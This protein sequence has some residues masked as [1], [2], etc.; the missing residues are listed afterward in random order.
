[1]QGRRHISL[2]LT[3]LTVAVS[4]WS[5]ANIGRPSGGEK[6]S[7][8][9]EVLGVLPYPGTLYFNYK[10]IEFHFDEF[11][12]PGNYKDEVFISPMPSVDP[13]VVVKNKV[14]RIKFLGPLR[15]N[16]TYV[17][18]LGTGIVDYNEGNKMGQSYTYA[19]STG[20]VLDSLR[21]TGHVSDMWTGG[22]EVNMRIMLFRADAIEVDEIK[23]KRPEYLVTTDKEGKF[24]FKYLA[25]GEY[26]IYGVGDADNNARY[27]GISE[28]I[29]LAANPL[30]VLK[31]GDS[32]APKVEMVA[33]FQDQDAP[34]AKSAKWSNAYTIHVEF[35]EP[36]RTSFGDDSLQIELSDT[37]GGN[38]K[39]LLIKRFRD[40]D[41]RHLYL[42]ADVPRTQD[43]DLH[44]KG[45]LDSLGQ[46]SEV[47][48]R[49]AA[50]SQVRE[51]RNKWFETPINERRGHEFVVHT[52]FKL[53]AQLD[54]SQVQLLD[55]AGAPQ[56]VIWS[57]DG[58]SL[59]AKSPTML[60]PEL[61]YT[62]RLKKNIL[63]PDGKSL[64]TLVSFKMTFPN[65]DDYGTITG[66][67]LADSTRPD[68]RFQMI[69]RGGQGTGLL[70]KARAMDKESKGKS[71]GAAAVVDRFEERFAA[72]APF[73]FVYLHPGNYSIDIIDDLDGNGVL[74]P[75]SLV[76]YR[77]PEKVYHQATPVDIKAKWDLK[78][79]EIYP[80]PQ[81]GKA[82]AGKGGKAGTG[83]AN[84]PTPSPK[85]K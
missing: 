69:L 49:V 76:P 5:C 27:T 12:K 55:T 38:R 4:V 24:D 78:D 21:F 35:S 34:T 14:L 6:D 42:H 20:A 72:P 33:F 10:E 18:T 9:P 85:G 79:V 7:A 30:I 53:P 43:Y 45:L 40:H 82:T 47:K 17:V 37:N 28:K 13:E 73:H 77:M 63:M 50:Q 11:I 19:F 46:L 62:L 32:I 70:A 64:D 59:R 48:V 15:E 83:P 57:T 67:V 75:G 8:G 36:I 68:A 31:G 65:P 16:T 44:F 51:E 3:I 81:V 66:R 80:I 54:S 39:P 71:S 26:K 23:A 52:L 58:F 22:P 84:A 56:E 1:M 74:T 61:T 25:P 60:K 29:A 2:W 41:T